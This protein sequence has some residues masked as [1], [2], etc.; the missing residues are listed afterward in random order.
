MT[1]ALL[2]T[3][4]QRDLR[5]AVAALGQRFGRDYFT[6]VVRDG[7]HTDELWAEAGQARL[8]RR[9]PPRGVRRRRRR[10]GRTVHRAG[11]VGRG[12]L[13]AAD[14]GRLTRHLRHRHR[15]VRHRGAEARSGCRDSP[16]AACTM[17]F[18]ITEPDAGS[19]SHRITTTA[20]RDG[21]GL[22]AHRPQ[23]LHL[24]RRHRRRHP[25]RRAA[26][27]T[28]G[29][30]SSSRA[31]SSSRATP[32]ASSAPH[33]DMELA[34]PEKQFELVTGRRAAA[35]RR[36]GRRRGRGAAPALRRAQPRTHHDGRLR[37]SAWAATRSTRPWTTPVPARCGRSPSA[38]TRPSRTRS[39]RPTSS[40]SWPG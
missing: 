12:G 26:P 27:R 14:A 28:R 18:G 3:E 20:R 39:P 17:A 21:D 40:W 2:E 5:A 16:T 1:T 31:C 33:I 34:A 36:A 4:E 37:A 22:A 10:H 29:R 24:R 6:G 9:Q 30:A 38:R 11:G 7:Q 23:G 32:P 35:R 8:S 15:P 25:D 13:P 19:N